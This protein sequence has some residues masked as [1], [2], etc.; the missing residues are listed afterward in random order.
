MC[1]QTVIVFQF[2][3]NVASA[4]YQCYTEC[5]QYPVIWYFNSII[6]SFIDLSMIIYSNNLF[7]YL[8]IN[9][10]LQWYLEVNTNFGTHTDGLVDRWSLYWSHFKIWSLS[11]VLL[12]GQWSS[13][14]S[15]AFSNFWAKRF[16]FPFY[17]HWP[18]V[19]A[20]RH[21][22]FLSVIWDRLVIEIFCESNML[23]LCLKDVAVSRCRIM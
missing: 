1:V 10:Y 17:R 20:W 6:Y 23:S 7:I 9:D 3:N 22:P 18:L 13:F 16:F 21:T 8:F 11:R 2:C 19:R 4:F 14:R 12:V 15:F 5:K